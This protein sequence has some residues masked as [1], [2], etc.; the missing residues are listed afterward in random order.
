MASNFNAKIY[1]LLASIE[2]AVGTQIFLS[3]TSLKLKSSEGTYDAF[4]FFLADEQ[5]FRIDFNDEEIIGLAFWGEVGNLTNPRVYVGTKGLDFSEIV[6]LVKQALSSSSQHDLVGTD[7]NDSEVSRFIQ[8]V[9]SFIK[10]K[11]ATY[12]YD[13]YEAWAEVGNHLKLDKLSFYDSFNRITSK[14]LY[15]KEFLDRLKSI[16]GEEV[17]L[18]ENDKKTFKTKIIKNEGLKTNTEFASKIK[19][20]AS[21]WATPSAIV[22]CGEHINEARYA[23]K[24]IL[25]EEGVWDTKVLWKTKPLSI[26]Q[27]IEYLWKHRSES[28][29]VFDNIEET[30]KK[31]DHNLEM[32]IHEVMDS[33][34]INR[35]VKY[36]RKKESHAKK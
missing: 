29:L 34:K 17:V 18:S 14:E 19:S 16:T 15:K 32:I 4:Y 26:L 5:A 7:R 10:S 2:G 11:D 1:D 20:L 12:A 6:S 28:I 27:L 22:V 8:S 30:L 35:I 31:G 25:Q 23:I 9:G 3:P 36:S 21:E 24:R 33:N 13:S